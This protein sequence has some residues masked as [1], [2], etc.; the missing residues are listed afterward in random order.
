M[1]WTYPEGYKDPATGTWKTYIDADKV[2]MK[3]TQTRLD[4]VSAIVPLPL[5][6]DPRVAALMPGRL[7]DDPMGLDVTPNLWCT[8]DGKQ[9]MA[10]INSRPLLVP[11]QIDGF[12]C[13][14]TNP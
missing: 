2:V 7:I 1:M 5:G 8:P 10:E 4:L 9:L 3:S 6:P 12:G 14:D 13:L 11:V